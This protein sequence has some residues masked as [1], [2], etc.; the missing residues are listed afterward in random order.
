MELDY[1]GAP[2]PKYL[3]A[4]T[5]NGMRVIRLPMIEGSCPE[6]IQE[7]DAVI[8]MVNETIHKGENVL[9][10]CRGG[11]LHNACCC[12]T[13]HRILMQILP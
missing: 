1:L 6:T 12:T 11:K 2:W 13:T 4:A 5:Q 9:T 7:M 10:H 3:E 8:H